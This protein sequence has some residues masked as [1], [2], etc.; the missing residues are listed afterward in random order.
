VVAGRT[1]AGVHARGQVVH[2]DVD[3]QAFGGLVGRSAR[4]P[5]ESLVRR[6]AGVLAP[7][8]VV[9]AVH[10]VPVAFD[11]RFS[12]LGRRYCY[13]IGDGPHR[14]DPLRRREVL[15]VRDRLDQE[16]MHRAA[17]PLIGE[18][19]FV[20][21]CRPRPGAS[22]VRTL[23][24][25]D[26][27]RAPDQTIHVDLEADAFCHNQVRAVVGALLDV[28]RGRRAEEWPAAVLRAGRRDGSV[29]VAPPHGLTLEEVVYPPDDLLAEQA[30]RA[31][32][33]RGTA[34]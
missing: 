12:A 4:S 27:H 10:V 6:L 13:R 1:D 20:A 25:V 22:T 23:H 17:Q 32:R 28:G 24:R 18:H 7:D 11:A 3:P 30:E 31:R 29:D 34:T 16:A 14:P 5:A 26:V 15:W 2:A 33:Y 9:R 19:D 21:F 8:V